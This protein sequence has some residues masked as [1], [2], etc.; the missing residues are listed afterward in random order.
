MMW[1]ILIWIAIVVTVFLLVCCVTGVV[2]ITKSR[3][4][5][6]ELFYTYTIFGYKLIVKADDDAIDIQFTNL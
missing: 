6:K 2:L 1:N 4:Q 3:M 5:K